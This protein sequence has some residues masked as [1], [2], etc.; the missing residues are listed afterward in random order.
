MM[1]ESPVAVSSASISH[2]P[3]PGQLR[4]Q[5]Q[6]TAL[7]LGLESHFS[8][9]LQA[10]GRGPEMMVIPP[11]RFE[12]GAPEDDRDFG[13]LPRRQAEIEHGFGLG[14]YCVTADEFALFAQATGFEWRDDLLL[15]EGRAP[16]INI[17]LDQAQDYLA[18]LS[19]ET[20]RHYRLPTEQEWEYAA[21]AGSTTPYCFGD[22]LT[23]GEANIQTFQMTQS[24]VRGWRR[25]LPF[26]APLNRAVE[27]GTFPANVWGLHEVHGNVWEMT[28]ERW[29]GP[30]APGVRATRQADMGWFVVKGGS[31]FEGPRAARAAARKP[32][33][34]NELDINL[35]F[36]VA[37][38]LP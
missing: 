38:D 31:W 35:G 3:D 22:R 4:R 37:C 9:P 21:L 27:V 2:P 30:L 10:G 29:H 24:P 23:C 8:D 36:R 5:Q 6:E 14:R 12:S 18:W 11:G 13:E 25:F 16:V 20:G 33:L 17:S 1:L 28:S 34:H 7:R 15:A 26:C 32:R 19:E